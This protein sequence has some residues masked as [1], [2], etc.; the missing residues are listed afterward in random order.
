[1]IANRHSSSDSRSPECDRS[2]PCNYNAEILF[3]PDYFKAL[4]SE[5]SLIAQFPFTIQLIPL[6]AMAL[7]SES[8][9]LNPNSSL[10]AS[11]TLLLRDETGL[12]CRCCYIL[13]FHINTQINDCKSGQG[14]PR[15][16]LAA[17]ITHLIGI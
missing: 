14:G 10:S 17:L 7:T 1:M 6:S 3:H 5:R 15:N 9:M 13:Y 11:S 16:V 12:Q 8:I 2:K 4:R